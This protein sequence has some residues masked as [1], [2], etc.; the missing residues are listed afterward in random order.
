PHLVAYVVLATSTGS[1]PTPASLRAHL[2]TS[3][4]FYML[5]AAFV[6][7]GAFPMTSSGKV[8]R[9][10]LPAPPTQQ[11]RPD[12]YA[13]PRTPTE[14]VLAEIWREVLS[15]DRVGRDDDYFDLGGHSLLAVRL[16]AKIQQRFGVHLTL[17]MLFRDF[18]VRGLAR[19]IEAS[20]RPS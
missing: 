4:P 11:T 6:V 12:A 19:L 3:L 8:D 1:E 7:L 14:T 10:A 15:V 17:A 18:T 20:S 5:P 9:R 2:K 13:P 16:M